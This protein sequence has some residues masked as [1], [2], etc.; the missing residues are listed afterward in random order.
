VRHRAP[1]FA[2]EWFSVVH[3]Q[4]DRTEVRDLNSPVSRNKVIA[5]F[6][7]SGAI[8]A[9]A[10]TAFTVGVQQGRA[11]ESACARELPA[12]S[13]RA[14][15]NHRGAVDSENRSG[16][17]ING[18]RQRTRFAISLSVSLFAMDSKER[19]TSQRSA[20]HLATS[21][22]ICSNFGCLKKD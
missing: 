17:A 15:F 10:F 5:C 2:R 16:L 1:P 18:W 12:A 3:F 19:L 9:I 21:D 22:R 14:I 13:N 20:I 6:Q 7:A 11:S 8:P 4:A